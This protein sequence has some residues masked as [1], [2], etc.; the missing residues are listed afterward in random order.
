MNH[1]ELFNGSIVQKAMMVAAVYHHVPASSIRVAVYV[2]QWKY[3]I[4]D[5]NG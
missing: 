1:I 5:D 4:I 3:F 2:R